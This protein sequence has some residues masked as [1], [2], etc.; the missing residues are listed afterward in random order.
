[1]KENKCG[2]VVSFETNDKIKVK[3]RKLVK[4]DFTFLVAVQDN[5]GKIL[6]KYVSKNRIYIYNYKK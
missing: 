3:F 5:T 2:F 6:C 1:M 4:S